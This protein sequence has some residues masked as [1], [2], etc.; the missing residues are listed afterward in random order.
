MGGLVCPET[1]FA[2]LLI[3][4]RALVQDVRPADVNVVHFFHLVLDELVYLEVVLSVRVVAVMF[5]WLS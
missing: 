4:L 1:R 5:S 3:D 2:S